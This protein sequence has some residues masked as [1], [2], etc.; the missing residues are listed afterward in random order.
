MSSTTTEASVREAVRAIIAAHPL[1]KIIGQPTNTTV[2][3]LKRQAAKLAAAMNTTKLEGRHGH[4]ALVID[5]A[6]YRTVTGIAAATV[7]RLVAPPLI[8]VGLVNNMTI[9]DRTRITAQHAIENQEYWKQEAVDAITVERIVNEVVDP[10]YVEELED[11]YVGYSSQTIKTLIAHL[12]TEWCTVTTLE[13]KQ[14]LAAFNM[15]W[16]F[17]S[18][19][20]KFARELD[21]QQKIRISINVPAAE[22]QKIQIYVE[23]MYAS[24]SLTTKR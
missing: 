22:A 12:V 17:T 16:D 13:K 7:T 1:D 24:E 9:T 8:P 4:H 20:T 2:N 5:Q 18:H 10:T 21:K 14:A 23:N 15:Q 19:I 11:D 6:E 3:L